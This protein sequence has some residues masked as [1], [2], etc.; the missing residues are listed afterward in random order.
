MALFSSVLGILFVTAIVSFFLFLL[1]LD[2]VVGRDQQRSLAHLASLACP[3][4]GI[5]FGSDAANA[6]RL[7]GEKKRSEMMGKVRRLGKLLRIVTIWP[8]TCPK[9]GG[10]FK[11]R[12]DNREL[13]Q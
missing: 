7:E 5:S 4:C 11:F 8:V 6:A 13:T 2:Y 12:P 3:Q 1:Y 9:C 10:L